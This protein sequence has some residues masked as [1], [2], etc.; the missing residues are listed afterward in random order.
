MGLNYSTAFQLTG[1]SS[2]REQGV[3]GRRATGSGRGVGSSKRQVSGEST[4]K[5]HNKAQY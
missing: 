4:T 3:A 5:L 2:A 1:V